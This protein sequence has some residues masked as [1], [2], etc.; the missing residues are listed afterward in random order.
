[1]L[2]IGTI[3]PGGTAAGL[4]IRKGDRILTINDK[5]VNDVIDYRF[6]IADPNVAITLRTRAG[7]MRILAVTKEPDDTLGLEFAPLQV[8]RCRNKCIFCFVDQMP[9]GCRKSLYVKD[10]DFRASFL[11]GNYITLGALTESDWQRIFKER[12]SPLYISVH[13]TEPR[14]RS[15]ILG[16]EK[17]PDVMTSLQRLAASGIRMH[18]QIVLCPE[19]ND[20]MHLQKT[21]ADLSDLFPAIASIAVVPVGLTDFRKGLFPLRRFTACEAK[22]VIGQVTRFGGSFKKK[23]GT[24]LVFASDE[25]Y[26]KAGISVPPASFYEDFPQIENGVGMVAEF[27]RGAVNTRLPRRIAPLR[28]TIVTGVSFS[29]VLGQALSRLK[30]I[31]GLVLKQITARNYFF[32]SS[33]T[34]AGLLTGSDIARALEGKRRGDIVIIPA[35]ALKVEDNIFLDGMSLDGLA[36]FLGVRTFPAASFK[37]IVTLLSSDKRRAKR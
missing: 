13:T 23:N 18:T 15:F 19:I 8:K 10:D 35:E 30:R 28:A 14:L 36:D 11:Y 16:N 2:E 22:S 3:A 33:V 7:K 20:G 6:H 25:F 5:V 32:G 27:L 1:V 12:L 31:E 4:D 34:V 9:S 24:R 17:A 26:I 37:E 29:K 21:L